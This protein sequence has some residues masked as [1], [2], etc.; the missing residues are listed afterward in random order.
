[1]AKVRC[2]R[3]H[4]LFVFLLVLCAFS[5]INHYVVDAAGL[6]AGTAAPCQGQQSAEN[7]ATNLNAIRGANLHGEFLLNADH[8]FN[9]LPTLWFQVDHTEPYALPWQPSALVRPPIL[10]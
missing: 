3:F 10:S 4:N 5:L 2:C 7:Y 1:M 8:V 6:T 9:I